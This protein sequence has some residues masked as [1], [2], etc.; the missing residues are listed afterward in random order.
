MAGTTYDKTR[1]VKP[2]GLIAPGIRPIYMKIDFSKTPTLAADE[3]WEILKVRDGW[4][5][6]DG[7]TKVS[8]ASAS[9]ATVDIGTAEDGTQL[10]TAIDI[11]TLAA[12]WTVMDTLVAGTPI[13]ITADGYIWLDFNTAAVTDGVLEIL[14]F[15]AC[16]PNDDEPF[17]N[18]EA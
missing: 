7:Y 4:I 14:L 13:I 17:G 15:I 1:V 18:G 8:I 2:L 12:D 6:Y 11:S 9:T 16:G 3:N 5:L 10:D